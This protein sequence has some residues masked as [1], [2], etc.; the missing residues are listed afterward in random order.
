MREKDSKCENLLENILK[1]GNICVIISIR[2]G[3]LQRETPLL[4]EMCPKC[5]GKLLAIKEDTAVSNLPCKC[6]HC[7]QISLITLAPIRAEKVKS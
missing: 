4:W 2:G 6:K 7:K 5:G 3:I 1:H